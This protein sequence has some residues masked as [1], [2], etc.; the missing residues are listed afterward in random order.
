MQFKFEYTF[1][2]L[3]FRSYSG[4]ISHSLVQKFP[5][6]QAIHSCILVLNYIIVITY[7]SHNDKRDITVEL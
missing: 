3:D 1:V 7:V 5:L 2:I 6:P 4:V